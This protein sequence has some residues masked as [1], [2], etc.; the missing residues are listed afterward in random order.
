MEKVCLGS[1]SR[2][3]AELGRCPW[4][5]VHT[6]GWSCWPQCPCTGWGPPGVPPRRE[7][8]IS[9]FPRFC[10]RVLPRAPSAGRRQQGSFICLSEMSSHCWTNQPKGSVVQVFFSGG[11]R[12]RK[13]FKDR[14]QSWQFIPLCQGKPGC[15][16]LSVIICLGITTSPEFIDTASPC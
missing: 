10:S 7:L 12:R 6:C 5:D 1:T 2:S 14:A 4:L 3:G 15:V 9:Q 11:M 16:G 8:L 13:V